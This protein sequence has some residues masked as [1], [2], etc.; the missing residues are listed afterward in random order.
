MGEREMVASLLT[1]ATGFLWP[2]G[3]RCSLGLQSLPPELSCW[4]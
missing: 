4:R 1:V 3:F 2:L